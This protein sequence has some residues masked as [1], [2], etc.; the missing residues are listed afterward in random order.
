M[1]GEQDS[2]H[3]DYLGIGL[4]GQKSELDEITRGLTLWG[5]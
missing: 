4:F 2:E 3:L 1:I 5:K